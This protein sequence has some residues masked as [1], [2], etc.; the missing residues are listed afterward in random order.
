MYLF[1]TL[2]LP[3]GSLIA[4]VG[5]GGKS[6]LLMTLGR[7]LKESEK[8]IILTSTTKMFF[9]QVRAFAPAF[10]A[11]Y[12]R[13]RSSV[14]KSLLQKGYAAWFSR[15]RGIKVD[16]IPSAWVNELHRDYNDVVILVE[17]DGARRKLLK[18]PGT[19]EPSAPELTDQVLGVLSLEALG[20]RLT[21]D[22][23]HR[24]DK[25]LQLLG[26]KE[27]DIIEIE[28]IA[29]LAG[30]K[31]G[32]FSRCPGRRILVLSGMS[33]EKYSR[34]RDITAAVRRNNKAGIELCVITRGFGEN[35]KAVEVM[36]P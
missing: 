35:M 18:A 10:T 6:S 29:R 14:R 1:E 28:D 33:N 5:A 22:T 7:E 27:G 15:W 30:Y 26:K 8:R 2:S 4:C 32:I 13:G 31:D 17:A 19:H 16:G 11:D 36:E 9:N 34:V 21:S 20:R 12:T 24:L 23:V 25:V 3:A